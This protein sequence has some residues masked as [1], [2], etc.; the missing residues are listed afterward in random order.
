MPPFPGTE[1]KHLW[2]SVGYPVPIPGTELYLE[3]IFKDTGRWK[4]PKIPVCACVVVRFP[5][6]GEALRL[7]GL[8]NGLRIVLE[9]YKT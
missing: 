1:S 3:N 9:F 2:T 8:R 6:E 7:R 4:V 5:G